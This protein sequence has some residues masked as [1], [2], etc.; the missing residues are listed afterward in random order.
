MNSSNQRI[1]RYVVVEFETWKSSAYRTKQS[2]FVDLTEPNRLESG[3]IMGSF[4]DI[5]AQ[6]SSGNH[7][8]MDLISN[9]DIEDV[10]YTHS[11]NR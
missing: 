4:I 3:R 7:S 11:V 5:V 9:F 8:E 2:L 1:Y 10:F 6:Q